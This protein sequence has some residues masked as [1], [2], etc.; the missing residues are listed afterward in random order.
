MGQSTNNRWSPVSPIVLQQCAVESYKPGL[1]CAAATANVIAAMKSPVPLPTP[2]SCL[3]LD[4]D[5]T[6]IEFAA[7]PALRPVS[8]DLT[9]LLGKVSDALDGALAL[10]SGRRVAD[11]DA[12]FFPLRLRC[13]GVHGGERRN[14]PDM[15]PPPAASED[16]LD[17]LRN[18]MQRFAPEHPGVL[19]EDKLISYVVHYRNNPAAKAAVEAAL[20]PVLPSLGPEFHALAGHLAIEIKPRHFSK[21]SAIEEFL[22]LPAFKGRTP[23][24]I[25]DD[26]TDLDGFRIIERRQGTSIAVG[27]RVSAQWRLP[28]PAAARAWLG[29]FAAVHGV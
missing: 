8:A 18:A 16:R 14:E 15:A 28:D 4:V 10:I 13:A 27:D 22:H 20:A 7:T 11:L 3:F 26:I 21:S 25:G 9:A 24:F 2:S 23:M 12:I 5:G 1:D 29:R 17:P 19:L 6:L